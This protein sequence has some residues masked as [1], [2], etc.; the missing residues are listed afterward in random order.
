ML[1]GKIKFYKIHIFLMCVAS[2]IVVVASSMPWAGRWF[3]GQLKGVLVCQG[4][5]TQ[6]PQME[7]FE[8]QKCTFSQFWNWKLE[9][10]VLAESMSSEDSPWL[11]GGRLSLCLHRACPLCLSVSRSPLLVRMPVVL[12]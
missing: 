12:D 6:T 3:F 9:A 10:K 7:W 11:A 2:E 8:Q 1:R 5:H 4:C